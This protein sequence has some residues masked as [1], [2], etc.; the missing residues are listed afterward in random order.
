MRKPIRDG[1]SGHTISHG[2]A[3]YKVKSLAG[4]NLWHVLV[5][6]PGIP[7]SRP[8][9]TVMEHGKLMSMREEQLGK[10]SAGRMDTIGAKPGDRAMRQSTVMVS[11]AG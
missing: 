8:T 2:G 6:V 7:G 1:I 11:K 4:K 3:N 9:E 10:W 5:S